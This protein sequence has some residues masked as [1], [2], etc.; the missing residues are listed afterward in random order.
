M[1]A[2]RFQTIQSRAFP[3]Y[4]A[5]T[6]IKRKMASVVHNSVPHEDRTAS[7][8]R[9]HHIEPVTIT[10]IRDINATTRVL[11]LSPTD[12][13]HT[14]KVR[15]SFTSTSTSDSLPSTLFHY[16]VISLLIFYYILQNIL[17]QNQPTISLLSQLCH[18]II[19]YSFA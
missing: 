19:K 2:Q 15:W 1:F 6:T 5:R 8:P 11:R 7:E 3:S 16:N 13:N 14:I 4:L 10:H 9:Q 17:T 18:S 12:P